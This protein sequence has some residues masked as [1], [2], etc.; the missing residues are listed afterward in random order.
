MGMLCIGSNLPDQERE[1]AD[2]AESVATGL[3][4]GLLFGPRD[5]SI[6]R[7]GSRKAL[8]AR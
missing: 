2:I 6:T 8:P 3:C 5:R 4:D 1:T 7:V